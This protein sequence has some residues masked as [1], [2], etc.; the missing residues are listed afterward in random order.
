MKYLF[1][2]GLNETKKDNNAKLKDF[3]EL[4]QVKDEKRLVILKEI[5]GK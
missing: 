4:K 3:K 5:N 2:F 1:G